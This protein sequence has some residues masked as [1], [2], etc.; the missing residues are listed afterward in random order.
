MQKNNILI[1]DDDIAIRESLKEFF[2]LS[3]FNVFTAK[4]G[5]EAL[6]L[7]KKNSEIDVVVT[8]IMMPGIDGLELTE[9]IKN[10]FNAEIIIMTG[11]SEN[12]SYEEAIK[13]GAS[14]IVF[15]PIRLKELLLR[16][17]R[18]LNARK[19]TIE[20]N[21]MLKKLHK[22]AI[23]DGLTKLFNSRKFY[24]QLDKEV[25]RFNRYKHSL[26]LI[27]LDIDLFKNFNDK[28]GHLEGDKVLLKM[29]EVIQSSLRT[30]D[31]GYRYG[32]EE[33]TIILPETTSKEAEKVAIRIKEKLKK[34]SFLQENGENPFVTASFGITCYR[35]GE[36]IH[37]FVNRVD[38]ALYESKKNGRDQITIIN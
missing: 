26:S 15:K 28:Y 24:E 8:D 32:G 9:H 6:Q 12:Y 36:D 17:T 33:F 14:D 23:T 3:S 18:I 13:K 4:N 10:S 38:K 34:S 5:E 22:L 29:G 20:R 1:V 2:I 30:M 35:D 11:Y 25:N 16:V 27:M 21:T 37:S 31:S 19:I 7:L